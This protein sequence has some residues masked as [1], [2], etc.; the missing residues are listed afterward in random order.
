MSDDGIRRWVH[1]DF[2]AKTTTFGMTQDVEPILDHNKRL[3]NEPQRADSSFRHVASIPVVL[4]ERWLNEELARGNKSIR[5]GS[6]EFD[7]LV[8]RKINDPDYAYLR[9]DNRKTILKV[10]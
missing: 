9:T 1:Q 6:R 2:A 7:N 3:Q 8:R 5:W 4:M 10:R